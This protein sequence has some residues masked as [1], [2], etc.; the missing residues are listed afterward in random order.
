MRV[1]TAPRPEQRFVWRRH[2]HM[3]NWDVRVSPLEHERPVRLQNTEALGEAGAQHVWPSIGEHP[4]FL[5]KAP[6]EASAVALDVRG[7][8]H[9]QMKAFVWERHSAEIRNNVRSDYSRRSSLRAFCPKIHR[10]NLLSLVD[11]QRA[12][13]LRIKPEHPRS[14]ARIQYRRKI[15]LWL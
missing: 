5:R 14:A 7:V 9:H 12:R 15:Q 4:V 2:Q 6:G 10:M 1:T 11:E 13:I 8:K 3:R